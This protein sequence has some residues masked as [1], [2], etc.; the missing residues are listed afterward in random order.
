[1]YCSTEL[2]ASNVVL[3]I[4]RSLPSSILANRSLDSDARNRQLDP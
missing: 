1:V 4:R 2:A 3:D